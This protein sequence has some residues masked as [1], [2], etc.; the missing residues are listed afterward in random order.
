LAIK[1]I[2]SLQE[3]SDIYLNKLGFE[4]FK[5]YNEENPKNYKKGKRLSLRCIEHSLCEFSKYWK[6]KN[7][8]GKGRKKFEPLSKN[9][10]YKK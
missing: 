7:Q 10:L 3:K 1:K 9:D 8:I 6:M 5:Y 2:R 4:D